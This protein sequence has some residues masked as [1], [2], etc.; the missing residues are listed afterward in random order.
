MGW[1]DEQIR[2]RIRADDEQLS[3]SLSEMASAIDPSFS[4]GSDSGRK[5]LAALSEIADYFRIRYKDL[6]KDVTDLE[7]QLDYL[8]RPSGILRRRVRLTKGWQKDC[9]GPLL[10]MKKSGTIAAL[11]PD[12]IAGYSYFD[13]DLGKK[14][15]ITD[16]V[17]QEFDD[18]AYCFYRPLP[19]KPLNIADLIKY[20]LSG[21]SP[22]DFVFMGI[23]ALLCTLF[24]ML[25]PA[26][27]KLIFGTVI[28]SGAKSLLLP[29][30]CLAVGITVSSML[31]EI[32]RSAVSE[33]ISEKT[34]AQVQAAAMMRLLSLP[35]RF[36]REYSTGE[37][38][39]RLSCM[40]NVCSLISDVVLTAGFTGLF[41]L[42]YVG[43]M[44]SYS[45]ALVIPSLVIIIATVAA[46][47]LSSLARIKVTSYILES[48]AKESG[49]LF[50]LISGIQ[51]IRLAGAEKRAFAKWANVYAKTA[52]F[53][54]DPPAI[55]KYSG[56]ISTAITQIG[57]VVIYFC[58]VSSNVSSDGYM[59][60][61]AAYGMVLSAFM[62]LS[63]AICSAANLRPSLKMLNPILEAQPEA[64]ENK[65]IV[66]RLSG[67]IELNNIFFRYKPDGP[68]IL[69]NVSVKIR[70][71]QYV[72]VVG[73][74]GCG[75][76][77]LI[78]LLLGFEKPQKGAVYYDGRDVNEMDLPSLRRNIGVV[79]QDGK[80][81]P[82]DIYSNITIS[83][84]WLTVD[85]AWEAARLAGV[86]EDI[87]QMP[88]GMNTLVG[89]DTG[90]ISGGQSQRLMIARAIA[91]RPRVLIFDEATSALDNLTQKQVTQSLDSLKCTRI[92]VAH[93]LST[94]RSCNRIIVLDGG[95]IV[96]DGTYDELMQQK[97]G[98]FYELVARQQ[99]NAD[100][101]S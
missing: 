86:D 37:L 6:P 19:Q 44:V 51:K 26:I 71:G 49:M 40:Q 58:A 23:A 63:N 81:F 53:N 17:F 24:G 80:L 13:Y 22:N 92:V 74:T 79:L 27:T 18:E 30:S 39:S 36:F 35:P 88:M 46:T 2:D 41:S 5:Q 12:K 90:G 84:P 66:G 21:F 10:A 91:P 47:L 20:I 50:S 45:P 54:Y 87:A 59:A 33:R 77:T 69:N 61:N 70:P 11:L 96:Q 56:V 52:K 94:I 95:Q 98:L 73:K 57:L 93:R 65:K 7:G 100:H 14:I 15:R 32:T 76:S 25:T 9:T 78:R 8:L 28:P 62:T 4:A 43:Q 1:F 34:D 29:L 60:F 72:A 67:A 31:M 64:S 55:I 82:G 16:K 3:S 89:G 83:A 68:L 48:S 101:V 75:K 85:D 42:L 99:V 97:D 38:M